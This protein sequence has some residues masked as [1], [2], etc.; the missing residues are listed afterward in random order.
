MDAGGRVN[1][2]GDIAKSYANE[3]AERIRDF[4]SDMIEKG[5]TP[6]VEAPAYKRMEWEYREYTGVP[7]ARDRVHKVIDQLIE[8]TDKGLKEKIRARMG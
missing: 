2:C 7:E 8:E 3:K 5:K 6:A 4:F 1:K